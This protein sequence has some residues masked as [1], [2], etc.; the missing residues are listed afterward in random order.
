MN[1]NFFSVYFTYR[2]DDVM[3][4]PGLH[5]TIDYKKLIEMQASQVQEVL[6][7]EKSRGKVKQKKMSVNTIENHQG[8]IRKR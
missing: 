2:K 1:V 8:T 3:S 6:P 5:T 7:P 4:I